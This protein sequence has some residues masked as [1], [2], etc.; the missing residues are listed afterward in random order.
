[1]L[2]F[3]LLVWLPPAETSFDISRLQDALDIFKRAVQE[4][5]T[6]RNTAV[7]ELWTRV[8]MHIA[9]EPTLSSLRPRLLPKDCLRFM[10]K[11]DM[12][13]REQ[14]MKILFSSQILSAR[15]GISWSCDLK[16][17]CQPGMPWNPLESL[18]LPSVYL[19]TPRSLDG[20]APPHEKPRAKPGPI[21]TTSEVAN[22][23]SAQLRSFGYVKKIDS[24]VSIYIIYIYIYV[25][26]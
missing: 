12:K 18:A 8:P 7:K 26:I 10:A 16:R 17:S 19:S 6:P 24:I 9:T 22:R 1:M 25:R 20:W 15:I 4:V 5:A 11:L 13:H 2:L 23:F 3:V 14:D 21:E